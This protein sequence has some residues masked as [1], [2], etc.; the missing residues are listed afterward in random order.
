MANSRRKV[1]YEYEYMDVIIAKLNAEGK[2]EWVKNTPLR[3]KIELEEHKHV[4]KQYIATASS[5]AIYIMNNEHVKNISIY[6]RPD[7]S[8]EDF[9]PSTNI[10]GT[11]FVC[12]SIALE[13]GAINRE[14]IFC[15][16]DYCFAPIQ[17][18]NASFYPPSATEIFIKGE[19]NEIYIYTEDRGKDRFSKI[20]L[21]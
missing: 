10:H 16:E 15:N 2:F 17:E 3:N 21:E 13:T 7:Y 12:A 11:N 5:K 9:K 6:E 18:R 8:P 1:I 20:I 14:L 19:G 4:F